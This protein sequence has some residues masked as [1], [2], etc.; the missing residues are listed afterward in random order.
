M[1]LEGGFLQDGGGVIFAVKGLIHPPHRTVAYPKYY[2]H[3]KGE[4]RRGDTRYR[5]I[6][7]LREGLKLLR[8]RW[9]QYLSF[10]PVLGEELCEIPHH[11]ILHH[12]NPIR[13][14][15][16]LRRREPR[17]PLER[18]TLELVGLILE[19]ADLPPNSVG[20]SGSV[21]LGLHREG[22]DIDLIF[23]GERNCLRAYRALGE[24]VKGGEGGVKGYGEED[25]KEL[26]ASRRT[27]TKIPLASFLRGERGKVLQGRFRN[28]HYFIRLVKKQSEA[29]ERYGQRR[30]RG[31]GEIKLRA[32]VLEGGEAIFTPCR[33]IIGDVEVLKGPEVEGGITEVASFRG[34]FC[35]HA[36]K[37]D[38]VKVVGKLEKVTA[39][40]H[41]YGR[42]LLGGEREHRLVRLR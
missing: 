19:R 27:D 21:L 35:E 20:I 13:G 23:Y 16:E 1:F 18:E 15:G 39:P 30:Y 22:S 2:P 17:D 3:P 9:P 11:S 32:R 8:E 12:F 10:D 7:S 28:H 41:E 29:G 25:L 14:L 31:L 38:W 36:Q 42:V 37:G 26:Y 24:L 5:R 34:R 6:A 33:Y 40:D 4:R